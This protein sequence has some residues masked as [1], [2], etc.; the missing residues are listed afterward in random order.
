MIEETGAALLEFENRMK[1]ISKMFD[2]DPASSFDSNPP[3][4][5]KITKDATEEIIDKFLKSIGL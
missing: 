3:V 4:E 1:N 2:L 5:V